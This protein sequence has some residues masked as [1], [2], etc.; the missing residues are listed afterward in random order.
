MTNVISNFNTI[1]MDLELF[2]FLVTNES[3]FIQ[4]HK[5]F[6]NKVRIPESLWLGIYKQI[7]VI[8]PLIYYS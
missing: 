2:K 4:G 5:L 7:Y 8:F 6:Q 3:E 1:S